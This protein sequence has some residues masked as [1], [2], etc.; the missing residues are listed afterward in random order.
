MNKFLK[1]VIRFKC[2]YFCQRDICV[3]FILKVCLYEYVRFPLN[4]II[5]NAA[6]EICSIQ[7]D[8]CITHVRGSSRGQQRQQTA[9]RD[10]EVVC[11]LA[12]EVHRVHHEDSVLAAVHEV[13]HRLG[14]VTSPDL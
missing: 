11:E 12:D 3:L 14:R 8:Q 5:M 2:Q 6:K 4:Y 7:L 1:K 13:D 10:D 9:A